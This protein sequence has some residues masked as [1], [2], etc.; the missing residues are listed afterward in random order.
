MIHKVGPRVL[1]EMQRGSIMGRIPND[2]IYIK[3][4]NNKYHQSAHMFHYV[5]ANFPSYQ[6]KDLVLDPMRDQ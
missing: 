5:F 6:A 2:G 1:E 3:G 4:P